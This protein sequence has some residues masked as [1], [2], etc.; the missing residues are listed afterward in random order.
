LANPR[1]AAAGSI[2][3][4]DPAAVAKR[5]LEAILYHVSFISLNEKGIEHYPPLLNTH[6]GTLQLLS[7]VGFK[8]PVQEQRVFSDIGNVVKFCM[9][10]EEK[11]DRLPYEI[12]GMVVKTDEVELQQQ[13]GSTTHHPRWAIA[14][15]FKARQASS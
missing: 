12:D 14:Y 5:K 7:E 6:S 1:N 3:M 13:A 9:E 10:F 8:T 4:K 15:K 2:R 11:R